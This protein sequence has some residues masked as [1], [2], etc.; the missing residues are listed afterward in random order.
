MVLFRQ[1][2]LES[3]SQLI[4]SCFSAWSRLVS[5]MLENASKVL[6]TS[7]GISSRPSTFDPSLD[8]EDSSLQLSVKSN[9]PAIVHSRPTLNVA[10][11]DNLG[12]L[13][14][15]SSRI[16][17]SLQQSLYNRDT[18]ER[19]T[20]TVCRMFVEN[21]PSEHTCHC[22][23]TSQP[24][25]LQLCSCLE[26]DVAQ[27]IQKF[28]ETMANFS[29]TALNASPSMSDSEPLC[30]CPTS[31]FP[32]DSGYS[33]HEPETVQPNPFSFH[34][35]HSNDSRNFP[36]ISGSHSITCTN[37]STTKL[38]YSAVCCIKNMQLYSCNQPFYEWL[39]LTRKKAFLRQKSAYIAELF[40]LRRLRKHFKLWR[41][42]LDRSAVLNSLEMDHH[43][44]VNSHITRSCFC[45]WRQRAE[46]D[47]NCA[48]VCNQ[49]RSLTR[50]L[51]QWKNHYQSVT[52][53]KSEKVGYSKCYM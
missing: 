32:Q 8:E 49:V 27:K 4:S 24:L 31:L 39:D 18:M 9:S 37:H 53:A 34:M 33:N 22:Q 21:E 17:Q 28:Q 3:E 51:N 40:R 46:R 10:A 1:R 48:E 35:Q 30:A 43:Y 15:L 29:R 20:N 26:P 42:L 41:E 38:A 13:Q 36:S 2:L 44:Q 19:N 14:D 11:I 5:S 7:E 25:S 50:A 16:G 6:L 47:Q 45:V 52:E 12:Y 23:S